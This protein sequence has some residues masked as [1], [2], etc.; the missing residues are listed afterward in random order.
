M[1]VRSDP[2]KFL[3]LECVLVYCNAA[4][5]SLT[6][7]VIINESDYPLAT[8][9]RKRIA[10]QMQK[11]HHSKQMEELV[12]QGA[13]MAVPMIRREHLDVEGDAKEQSRIF[14]VSCSLRVVDTVLAKGNH[15]Y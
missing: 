2:T 1:Q 14:R 8:V 10:K 4:E 9:L 7:T 12:G 11:S 13:W 5:Q 15:A 3:L 6:R